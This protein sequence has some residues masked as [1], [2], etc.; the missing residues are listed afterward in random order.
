MK[1]VMQKKIEYGIT[2]LVT[3]NEVL[4]ILTEN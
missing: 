3:Y 4:L 1:L 2:F